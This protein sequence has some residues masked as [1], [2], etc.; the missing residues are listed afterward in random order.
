MCY[1][2]R[3]CRL[4]LAGCV[5]VGLALPLAV[6]PRG[7]SAA[8]PGHGRTDLYG[9]P[10]PPGAVA[11][12]GSMRL[13]H[14]R[15]MGQL[16]LAFSPDGRLLATLG[17]TIRL[18]EV[19]TGRLVREIEHGEFSEISLTFSP[20][21]K[22]LLSTHDAQVWIW[23]VATG[24]GERLWA[25]RGHSG[26][27]E[28]AFRP[29]GGLLAVNVGQIRLYDFPSRKE[30]GVLE[31]K[32]ASGARGLTF[33]PDGRR[34]AFAVG[35][36]LRVWDVA[37]RK[38][39][40]KV[41]VGGKILALAF[42]A[43]SKAVAVHPADLPV[44][45]VHPEG[46]PRVVPT[47]VNGDGPSA[48]RVRPGGADF[49]LAAGDGSVRAFPLAGRSK[50][51]TLAPAAA[52]LP[53]F[54]QT[55][56][57]SPDGRWVAVARRGVIRV[58][59][60]KTGK[61]PMHFT[62][63]RDGS[64][65]DAV[66]SPDGRRAVTRAD[67]ELRVW[68]VRTGKPL[69][70][71][72]GKE[73]LRGV[74]W[75]PDGRH[76]VAS[77]NG[78][79]SWW[80]TE[81]GRLARHVALPPGEPWRVW[82]AADGRALVCE[83]YPSGSPYYFVLLDAATGKERGRLHGDGDGQPSVTADGKWALV[84]DALSPESIRLKEVATGRVAWKK[85]APGLLPHGCFSP[86]AG[87]LLATRSLAGG[88]V[89]MEVWETAAGA[90]PG[91]AL[92]LPAVGRVEMEVWETAAGRAVGPRVGLGTW[93][94]NAAAECL[95][96]N[97]RV[98]VLNAHQGVDFSGP[99]GRGWRSIPVSRILLLETSTGRVRHRLPAVGSVTKAVF[100]PDGRH[101]L[102]VGADATVLVWDA[103]PSTLARAHPGARLW[104]DLA[105]DDAEK[106]FA[107]VC[108]LVAA[109]GSAVKELGRRLKPVAVDSARV[110]GWLAELDDESFAG[111]EAA[112]RGLEALGEDVEIALERALAAKP[113]P[114]A[115]RRLERLLGR[116]RRGEPTAVRRQR[117]RALEVLEQVGTPEARRLLE[118]LAR[119]AAEARLTQEAKAAARRLAG[120]AAG[121]P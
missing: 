121:T 104:D 23:D 7:Q 63:H 110:R 114:E 47:R 14:L 41:E 6:P 34:L 112:G 53:A 25:G 85:E 99:L 9:D 96:P 43:D 75:A 1:H 29:D 97:G 113:A 16:P 95:S 8:P 88:G 106:A 105:V 109:P 58:L 37:A 86:D 65:L 50:P 24:K 78:R 22:K 18:W 74:G 107:A 100:S 115:R 101:F 81:T 83:F 55:V 48:L 119:G 51:Q 84:P 71:I 45:L 64:Y 4:G 118:A 72:R 62:D 44:S 79:A 93:A 82:P 89:E 91:G 39:A 59:D 87:L 76:V 36:T 38:E 80:D 73:F 15:V 49:L 52:G 27:V 56:A 98:V 35:T 11:R 94:S 40:A 30:V 17:W 46:R 19:P 21:G 42:S 28:V 68:E 20:D 70:R 67:G 26:P 108:R 5:L 90:V 116:L 12:L 33:S 2:E 57:L 61:E 103:Y 92:R 54:G 10:L 117:A 102:T 111:R 69:R 13:R 120:R 66:P 77:A 32:D 31:D 60:L 3:K